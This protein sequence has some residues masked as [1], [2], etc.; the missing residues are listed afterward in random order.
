MLCCSVFTTAPGGQKD[1]LSTHRNESPSERG[2]GG[3]AVSGIC[4]ELTGPTSSF[5]TTLSAT[6]TRR[7]PF[8]PR[9]QLAL[10][11]R[12]QAPVHTC[13]APG[14]GNQSHKWMMAHMPWGRDSLQWIE[15][16]ASWVEMWEGKDSVLCDNGMGRAHWVTGLL[17]PIP[18]S[19]EALS[20]QAPNMAGQVPVSHTGPHTLPH[21]DRQTHST[22]GGTQSPGTPLKGGP[23]PTMPRDHRLKRISPIPD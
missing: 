8:T 4:P 16:Q 21:A 23:G 12:S 7:G 3:T 11:G 20:H 1:W 13:S 10:R 5:T 22:P 18:L 6:A 14:P 9:L 17:P 15:L 2:S 19:V